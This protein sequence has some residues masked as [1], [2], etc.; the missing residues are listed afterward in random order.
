[1]ARQYFFTGTAAPTTTP[2]YAGSIFVDTTGGKIY[3][4]TGTT[5]S[6]DWDILPINLSDITI[7]SDLALGGLYKIKKALGM[8]FQP[9]SELTI[10]TGAV[11]QTQTLHSIDTQSDAASDDLDTIT[12]A[13]D[14]AV[15]LLSLENAARI[16]TLKHGTGNLNLPDN[17]DIVMAENTVYFLLY[18]GT[19]W[20]LVGSSASG[21]GDFVGPA[22][23]TD[24]AIVRFDSTTGKL[25]QNSGILIDD[26]DNITG[27]GSVNDNG[28]GT[29]NNCIG[30]SSGSSLT[31]GGYNTSNGSGSLAS[32]TTQNQN[33]AI[34]YNSQNANNGGSFNT[35]VGSN[36]LASSTTAASNACI[37]ESSLYAITTGGQNVAVGYYS[38][39]LITGGTANQT[40][41]NSLY[42]GYDTR[43][44]SDGNINEVVIGHTAI[45]SG[46]NTVTIGNTSVTDT[47]LRGNIQIEEVSAPST[48]AS[49]DMAIYADSTTSLPMAKN[50]AGDAIQLGGAVY[51]TMSFPAGSMTPRTTNGAASGTKEYTTNDI[52][53]DFF[54]FDAATNEGVQVA[55][56]V[57]EAWNLSTC[58]F[59]F[60]WTTGTTAGTGNV[61]W[62]V[63]AVA[64]S[65]DD[66]LDAAFGTAQTVTDGF[67]LAD[68]NHTT[69]ATPAVTVGGTPT[70]GD[71]VVFEFY[72]DAANV[73]DTYT[74]DARLLNVTMQYKT[75]NTSPAAW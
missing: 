25:G 65:N 32:S 67:L 68:D 19:A 9:A 59:K 74:Q 61:V 70:L 23:S 28:S 1:M 58:K 41:S 52:D 63:R 5:S 17:T 44:G 45:G 24:N 38:G 49:G 47:Y 31:T 60:V 26:S 71:L 11:T 13:T 56:L 15:L 18:N 2:T 35:S 27:L 55:F 64:I 69:A 20:N 66:P 21:S 39:R 10:A 29:N 42:L 62:G 4:A 57:D 43:A 73:S 54:D 46:S 12:I 48:P 30:T 36:S 40:S 7:D 75:L 14:M 51:K 3:F 16:V 22:S 37:G 33:V 8:D 34:G 53:L 72:R 50:D 6:A